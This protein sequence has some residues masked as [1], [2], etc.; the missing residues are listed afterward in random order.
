MPGGLNQ[1]RPRPV[2]LQAISGPH[3]AY[4]AVPERGSATQPSS[5]HP[6]TTDTAYSPNRGA[7]EECAKSSHPPVVRR[8]AYANPCAVEG[9]HPLGAHPRA[10]SCTDV[11]HPVPPHGKHP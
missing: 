9:P 11:P 6:P 8:R 5:E 7:E 2:H 10:H 1:S 3:G 4:P